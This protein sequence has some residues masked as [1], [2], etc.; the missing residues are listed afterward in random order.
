MVFPCERTALPSAGPVKNS[1]FRTAKL[2]MV[3]V[4]CVPATCAASCTNLAPLS[5][6][7]LGRHSVV[8]LTLGADGPPIP[9]TPT[10]Q[11][12]PPRRGK[13]PSPFRRSQ[14]PS[15]LLFPSLSNFR[16]C[17]YCTK[18]VRRLHTTI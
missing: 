13:L 18:N 14:T 2:G 8:Q 3:L 11:M 16:L 15:F 5:F 1:W 4:S 17:S 12:P 7:S 6:L 10:A 9:A